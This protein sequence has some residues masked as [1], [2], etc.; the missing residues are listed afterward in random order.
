MNS[1]KWIV[2]DEYSDGDNGSE[3]EMRI[4]VEEDATDLLCTKNETVNLIS[5][6]GQAREGKSTFMN[7]LAGVNDDNEIFKS[8]SATETV[9]TGV[10]ISK[11]FVS[12]KEFSKLND[13]PEIDNN[14]LVGFVDTEGQGNKGEEFDL[15]LFSPILVTSKIVIFWW[16]GNLQ[17]N[18]ILNSLGAITTSAKRI[19]RDAQDQHQNTKPYGHLHIIF[20]S[21]N[22]CNDST[23]EDIKKAL[24]EP[25]TGHR[26]DKEHNNIRE[27]LNDC[28][29]SIDI[30]LFPANGLIQ[31]SKRLHFENFNE[32]WKQ[33][34]KNMR[35]KFSEQLNVNEPKHGADKPWTGQDIAE[36]TKFQKRTIAFHNL[37]NE[38]DLQVEGYDDKVIDEY[39]H[40]ELKNFKEKLKL[41]S[42]SDNVVNEVYGNYKESVSLKANDIKRKIAKLIIEVQNFQNRLNE[43]VFNTVLPHSKSDLE[44]FLEEQIEQLW[45]DFNDIV[46][47]FPK[48]FVCQRRETLKNLCKE[49]IQYTMAEHE[50]EN[51]LKDFSTLV[52]KMNPRH[53]VI[54]CNHVGVGAYLYEELKNF[55]EKLKSKEFSDN[56]VDKIYTDYNES[57]NLIAYKTN[58]RIAILN[59]KVQDFQKRVDEFV[60]N[61]VLPYSKSDF[62]KSLKELAQQL[63][64]NLGDIA[65]STNFPVNDKKVFNNT[66]I[67]QYLQEEIL[68]FSYKVSNIFPYIMID[69]ICTKYKEDVLSIVKMHQEKNNENIKEIPE[70]VKRYVLDWD[71]LLDV[72]IGHDLERWQREVTELLLISTTISELATLP[73]FQLLYVCNDLTSLNRETV[74]SSFRAVIK[75]IRGRDMRNIWSKQFVNKIMACLESDELK[76]LQFSFINRCLHITTLA[77]PILQLFY[78]LLFKPKPFTFASSVI[79]RVFII[80]YEKYQRVRHQNVFFDLLV[81]PQEVFES[82]PD[83]KIINDLLKEDDLNSP[84]AALSCDIIQK[85]FFMNYELIKIFPMLLIHC[86]PPL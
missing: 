46:K 70:K 14:I 9:T 12:L 71:I 4:E 79:R 23:P 17:I 20:K 62:T 49:K 77:S 42:F 86:L 72:N 81:N 6:F 73:L 16:P 59:T 41:E 85:T 54:G 26:V 31:I 2:I 29:E 34:F 18:S 61:I 22:P 78:K 3:P 24:L 50:K 39:L 56:I 10:D 36:F 55:R 40:E 33:T 82:L 13:D 38:M 1:L 51:A 65:L 43:F 5:I 53:R 27:L 68:R 57:V 74:P 19:T 32:S 67:E 84:I 64:S 8:S 25:Q 69:D 58:D 37:I 83:L 44:E 30:W 76:Y 35:N 47:D 28:F 21:W 45:S 11:T 66:E 80:E 75:S 60:F 15:Y 48:G 52:N 7:I 63:R